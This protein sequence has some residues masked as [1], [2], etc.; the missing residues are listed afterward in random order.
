M[1]LYF[2]VHHNA[3][4][5]F[6]PAATLTSYSENVDRSKYGADGNKDLSSRGCI[7]QPQKS[8]D[9]SLYRVDENL[10]ASTFSLNK[11]PER[12][13]DTGLSQ[14]VQSIPLYLMPRPNSVAGEKRCFGLSWT[15]MIVLC[16]KLC[17]LGAEA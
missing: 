16:T 17:S 2:G 12:G 5:L 3:D 13:L 9:S 1:L 11:I 7:K 14:S 4:S 8:M 10:M 15:A 6:L